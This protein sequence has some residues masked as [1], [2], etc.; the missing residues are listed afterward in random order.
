PG[1]GSFPLQ[2]GSRAQISNLAAL[3]SA[4]SDTTC[5]DRPGTVRSLHLDSDSRR[6]RLSLRDCLRRR[7]SHALA[8]PLPRS[9]QFQTAPPSCTGTAKVWRRRFWCEKLTTRES[10]LVEIDPVMLVRPTETSAGL[11]ATTPL[12]SRPTSIESLSSGH[13]APAIVECCSRLES[14]WSTALR[15]SNTRRPELEDY[16]VSSRDRKLNGQSILPYCA[17]RLRLLKSIRINNG[18]CSAM[19]SLLA[20]GGFGAF[21]SLERKVKAGQVKWMAL[22]RAQR[23]LSGGAGSMTTGVRVGE[24]RLPPAFVCRDGNGEVELHCRHEAACRSLAAKIQAKSVNLLAAHSLASTFWLTC[25]D[26]SRKACRLAVH[27]GASEGARFAALPKLCLAPASP[28]APPSLARRRGSKPGASR[29]SQ[30]DVVQQRGDPPASVRQAAGLTMSEGSATAR[31]LLDRC[32]GLTLARCTCSPQRVTAADR[33]VNLRIQNDLLERIQ[34]PCFANTPGFQMSK[35]SPACSTTR[36]PTAKAAGFSTYDRGSRQR[37][38]F[39][40]R[41]PGGRGGLVVRGACYNFYPNGLYRGGR[42]LDWKYMNRL[43]P[44]SAQQVG[45]RLQLRRLLRAT[46]H[47]PLPESAGAMDWSSLIAIGGPWDC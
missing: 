14:L 43:R 42:N 13:N 45:S 1:S 9:R 15:C 20:E 7:R 32:D 34:R 8:L 37:F 12:P 35:S 4:V 41:R 2:R 47:L 28:V 16:S 5:S 33:G 23:S 17:E 11:S 10:T 24:L 31:E 18:T 22:W 36:W 46:V 30:L 29:R 27:H 26:L 38:G 21:K 3:C 40:S 25:F 44:G 6:S 39:C 19:A